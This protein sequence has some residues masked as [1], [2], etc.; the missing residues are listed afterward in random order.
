M[1]IS[2]SSDAARGIDAA[3]I[4]WASDMRIIR[5]EFDGSPIALT[6]VMFNRLFWR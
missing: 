1:E 6:A 2:L 3:E 5:P 4:R